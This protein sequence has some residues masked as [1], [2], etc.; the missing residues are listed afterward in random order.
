MPA[1]QEKSE[2]TLVSG[3]TAWQ[4][5]VVK[6]TGSEPFPTTQ[7]PRNSPNQNGTS[8]PSI[9][10][11]RLDSSF[12]GRSQSCH[13]MIASL[14]CPLRASMRALPRH[15]LQ[16][17]ATHLVF[18]P[19]NHSRSVARETSRLHQTYRHFSSQI[20][21]LLVSTLPPIYLK[22]N[23]HATLPSVTTPKSRCA[24]R[25]HLAH[26]SSH[27]PGPLLFTWNRRSLSLTDASSP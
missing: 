23:P 5:V 24:S 15:A 19:R 7:R 18:L 4:R 26:H 11:V 9:S 8:S 13:S 27:N 21:C 1:A 16:P 20:I 12:E 25:K 10:D 3:A 14:H 17:D 6:P 22:D 2:E